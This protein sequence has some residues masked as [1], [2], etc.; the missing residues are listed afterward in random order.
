MTAPLPRRRGAGGFSQLGTWIRTSVKNDVIRAAAAEKRVQRDIV[1]EALADYFKK[2][3]LPQPSPSK[4][5]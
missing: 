3:P 5:A 4:R 1:E 2:R